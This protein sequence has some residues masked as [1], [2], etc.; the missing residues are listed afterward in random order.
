MSHNSLD[1][2][3]YPPALSVVSSFVQ[4]ISEQLQP[5]ISDAIAEKRITPQRA[6][7]L[8]NP[9]FASN[10][11]LGNKSLTNFLF[12]LISNVIQSQT[13]FAELGLTPEEIE[14][15]RTAPS[16][17]PMPSPSPSPVPSPVDSSIEDLVE[18]AKAR[19][20]GE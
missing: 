5:I 3:P 6:Y 7:T 13:V 9:I 14:T 4:E 8:L 1:E 18:Y 17:P 11:Y 10:A 12:P 20:R 2:E 15:L 16:P 19:L